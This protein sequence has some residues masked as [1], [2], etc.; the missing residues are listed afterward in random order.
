MEIRNNLQLPE[1][2]EGEVFAELRRRKD[3]FR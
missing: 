2:S 1:A 3:H